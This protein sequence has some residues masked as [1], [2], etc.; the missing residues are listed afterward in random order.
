MSQQQVPATKAN[1]IMGCISKS[2]WQV[3]GSNRSRLF[4]TCETT[5]GIL[6]TVLVSPVKDSHGHTE[7]SRP[8]VWSGHT[9]QGLF[10]QADRRP[11]CCLQLLD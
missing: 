7:A 6:C 11:S 9:E 8:P 4:R 2:F 5:A 3:Q 1:P 10:S